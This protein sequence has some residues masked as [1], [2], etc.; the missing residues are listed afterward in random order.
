MDAAWQDSKCLL[1]GVTPLECAIRPIAYFPPLIR[2]SQF[3]LISLSQF[4]GYP[5]FPFPSLHLSLLAVHFLQPFV[6]LPF[7]PRNSFFH[8]IRFNRA[9]LHPFRSFAVYILCSF[10]LIPH[11]S[12][13]SFPYFGSTFGC[14]VRSIS[15]I[16]FLS[17]T[18]L[19]E[20][21]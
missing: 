15:S 1:P 10:L 9:H 18:S 5:D 7:F 2:P 4:A 6:P 14:T 8:L 21:P 16:H 19:F 11:R 17:A 20:P 13:Q 3:L 12:T